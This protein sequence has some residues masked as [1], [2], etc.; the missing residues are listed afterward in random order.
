M[1]DYKIDYD[2]DGKYVAQHFGTD[3]NKAMRAARRISKK[4]HLVYV[5]GAAGYN[6]ATYADVGHICFADGVI[7]ER[8]G[9]RV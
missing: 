4:G 2:D 1:I 8:D 5:V 3:R 9:E 7:V 6:R